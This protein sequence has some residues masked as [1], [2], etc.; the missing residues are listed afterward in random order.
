MCGLLG[1]GRCGW[2]PFSCSCVCAFWG[3]CGLLA[4]SACWPLGSLLAWLLPFLLRC[5]CLLFL[6]SAPCLCRAL[7]RALLCSPLGLA[8]PVGRAASVAQVLALCCCWAWAAAS[9]VLGQGLV[10]EL[11]GPWLG[12]WAW[13]WAW[14]GAGAGEEPAGGAGVLLQGRVSASLGPEGGGPP[15]GGVLLS[16]CVCVRLLCLG[17]LCLVWL[18]AFCLPLP[19]PDRALAFCSR[20]LLLVPFSLVLLGSFAP[21]QS[22]LWLCLFF[23]SF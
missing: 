9:V 1:Q 16:A 6:G 5:V 20:L 10:L 18:C 21:L 19:P 14:A 12:P 17:G 4:A 2:G 13:T 7:S 22:V 3:V 11:A 15:E 8:R 23:F